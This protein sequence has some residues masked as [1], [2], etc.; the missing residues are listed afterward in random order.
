MNVST[1]FGARLVFLFV[2]FFF[3]FWKSISFRPIEFYRHLFVFSQVTRD[4]TLEKS[5]RFLVETICCWNGAII[6]VAVS[7]LARWIVVEHFPSSCCWTAREEKE[8]MKGISFSERG[9]AA[10]GLKIQPRHATGVMINDPRANAKTRRRAAS[11]IYR[12]VRLV[13]FFSTFFSSFWG[14]DPHEISS[15]HIRGEEIISHIFPFDI[16]L[17]L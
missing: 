4:S 13:L 6:L 7:C 12:T 16:F 9:A 15:L 11:P 5:W 3:H 1:G 10:R 8:E 14:L 17:Y 2:D